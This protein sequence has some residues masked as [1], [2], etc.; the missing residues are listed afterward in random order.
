[1]ASF[2]CCWWEWRYVLTEKWATTRTTLGAHYW[3]FIQNP[4]R[5]EIPY[6]VGYLMES[7]NIWLWTPDHRSRLMRTE[8]V[9]NSALWHFFPVHLSHCLY[10]CLCIGQSLLKRLNSQVPRKSTHFSCW[11]RR[12]VM[13]CAQC[14]TFAKPTV[15]RCARLVGYGYPN[16][17]MNMN[18]D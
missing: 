2:L 14:T 8:D 11:S 12:L 3:F 17:C 5:P 15:K 10:L 4:W 1:M 7:I 13:A 18:C 16:R 9:Q 6:L